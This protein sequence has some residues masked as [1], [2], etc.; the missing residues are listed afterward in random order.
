MEGASFSALADT[1]IEPGL[2]H[3]VTDADGPYQFHLPAGRAR[4]YFNSL[5]DGFVYPNPQI[6]KRL[7]VKPRQA[8]IENLNLTLRKQQRNER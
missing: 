4:L 2:C 5:P 8:N 1:R 7:E 6:A 3:D